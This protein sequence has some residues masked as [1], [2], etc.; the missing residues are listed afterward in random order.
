MIVGR[1]MFFGAIN[2]KAQMAIKIQQ[3]FN[4]TSFFI[5][6]KRKNNGI[7]SKFALDLYQ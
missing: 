3:P 7:K 6:M 5:N 1:S 4:I 2:L